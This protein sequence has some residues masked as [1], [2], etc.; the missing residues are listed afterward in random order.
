MPCFR[1]LSGYRS[2]TVNPTGKRSIVFSMREA[3]SADPSDQVTLPCG[4]CRYCRLEHSRQWAIRAMHEASLYPQNSFITLTYD[5]EHLP[6]N[7]SLDYEAPQKFLKRLRK[8]T[9]TKIRSYG[10]AEYGEKLSRP[11]YHLCLFNYDFNDKKHW[12]TNNDNK[13]YISE[14]LS[15]LWP[16]GFSTIGDLTFETAAYVARYV[17]KKIT[18]RMSDSHYETLNPLSGEISNLLPERSIS[19][20]R[21]PGLGR[22]WL[23]KNRDF[24]LAHDFVIS[25]GKRVRPPKYYDRLIQLSHPEDFEEILRKRKNSAEFASE[26]T[27]AEDH[28]AMLEYNLK[29]NAWEHGHAPPKPRLYVMEEVLESK[30][31]QLKRGLENG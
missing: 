7:G 17:T 20:S 6:K 27:I 25:R 5:N 26:K 15:R 29:H 11:H 4:Q 9:N 13:L 16:Y 21:M 24:L 2:S 18:G 22:P 30:F 8:S 10:C 31:K 3:A 12:Q 19:V 28:K 1:P 23:E 14:Q